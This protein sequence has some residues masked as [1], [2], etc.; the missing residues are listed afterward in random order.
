MKKE[1]KTTKKPKLLLNEK[2]LRQGKIQKFDNQKLVDED[3][4]VKLVE[5]AVEFNKENKETISVFKD[6]HPIYISKNIKLI[7]EKLRVVVDK[8]LLTP[9]K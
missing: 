1:E 9:K 2:A 6:G 5:V 3:N 7:E 4:K 8:Y